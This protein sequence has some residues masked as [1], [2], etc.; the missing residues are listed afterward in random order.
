MLI[1]PSQ[2]GRQWQPDSHGPSAAAA[3]RELGVE[4][5][6]RVTGDHYTY[7]VLM[8]SSASCSEGDEAENN[9]DRPR[10]DPSTTTRVHSAMTKGSYD[11]FARDF[12]QWAIERNL[13]GHL[14]TEAIKSN[15]PFRV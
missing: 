7:T 11:S 5:Q 8:S 15:G 1:T 14:Y 12:V 10:P 3:A 9:M 13:A 6:Y 4:Q 2:A